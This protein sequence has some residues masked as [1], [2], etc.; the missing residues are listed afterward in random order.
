[1]RE[2]WT[3]ELVDFHGKYH[4][5]THT[6]INPLPVQRPIPVWFGVGSALDPNSPETAL[7][8]VAWLADGWRPNFA[9]DETGRR[10]QARVRD[11]MTGYG[12]DPDTLGLDGR[13]KTAGR[14]PED[15]IEEIGAW[16]ERG[17]LCFGG[18]PAGRSE[19]CRRTHRGHAAVQRSGGV[20]VL[21][22]RFREVSRW[23]LGRQRGVSR[24]SAWPVGCAP[25]HLPAIAAVPAA[26]TALWAKAHAPLGTPGVW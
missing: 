10:L 17:R 5:I 19:D 24:G 11:Y 4:D 1:M 2:L 18:E 3:K 13:L 12:R 21:Q 6:G 7:R 16:R 26:R 25:G 14:T 9:P 20:L 23:S 8:R 15:W 22:R